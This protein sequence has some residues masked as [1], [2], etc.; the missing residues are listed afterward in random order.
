MEQVFEIKWKID[1]IESIFVYQSKIQSRLE[2]LWDKT[3]WR[4]FFLDVDVED[5]KNWLSNNVN[6]YWMVEPH[7]DT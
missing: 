6:V 7:F 5:R 3:N 1:E 4:Q 2:V